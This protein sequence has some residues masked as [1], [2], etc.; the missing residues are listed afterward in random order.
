MKTDMTAEEDRNKGYLCCF[1]EKEKWV[2]LPDMD[3]ETISCCAVGEKEALLAAFNAERELCITDLEKGSVLRTIPCD[4]PPDSVRKL[5]FADGDR[6]LILF[7]VFG[8]IRV[9]DTASGEL[10]SEIAANDRSITG[11]TTLSFAEEG[12]F[13]TYISKDGTSLLIL[14]S[15]SEIDCMFALDRESLVC[16]GLFPDVAHY[17]PGDDSVL[18][19]NEDGKLFLC[20][21]RSFEELLALGERVISRTAILPQE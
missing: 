18:I 4:V 8:D 7:P 9:Y 2:A 17:F 1:W 21:F 20:P 14:Y 19:R 10:L 3:D 11:D 16:K 13:S 5:L 15:D 6:V 12:R